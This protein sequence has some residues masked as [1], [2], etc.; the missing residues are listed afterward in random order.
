MFSIP[1]I[2]TSCHVLIQLLLSF[3]MAGAPFTLSVFLSL[4]QSSVCLLS[5]PFLPLFYLISWRLKFYL[6][7]WVFCEVLAIEESGERLE[8]GRKT[9]NI[10]LLSA[11]GGTAGGTV[12]DEYGLLFPFR[13]PS[14]VVAAVVSVPR[15][16]ATQSS[17]AYAVY[18]GCRTSV[19]TKKLE[20]KSHQSWWIHAGRHRG[21]T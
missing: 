13:Q 21:N 16:S 9:E 1:H 10:S 19:I 15:A 14:S 20:Q 17:C 7:A 18:F 5:A 12:A 3:L 4:H 11:P 6:P 2:S 8:D